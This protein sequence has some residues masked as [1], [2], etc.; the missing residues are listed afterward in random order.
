M[1]ELQSLGAK[2]V[3]DSRSFALEDLY[4][5]QPWLIKPNQEEIS[6][7]FGCSV[8]GIR[9][10]AEKAKELAAH[11]ISNVMISLGQQGA[12]LAAGGRVLRAA[13][14][15]INAVSTVGAGDSSIAGF[16]AAAMKK[17]S[18]EECLG[19]AVAFGTAAC[20]TEGSLPP[21]RQTVDAIRQ[22]ITITQML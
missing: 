18:P 5:V 14:P 11:G 12:L 2:I 19:W 7:F 8:E 6:A 3:V 21:N 4:E 17:L 20:L 13:P 15:A 22:Q 1:R 16:I 9:D 10:G